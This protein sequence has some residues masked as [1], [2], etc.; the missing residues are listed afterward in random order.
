MTDAGEP[1]CYEEAMSD[2]NKEEWSEA[3][4]DE[5][6][7]LYENDT[8]ELVNLPKGKKALKNKWVYRVKT[9]E[10]TSHP[11][12]KVRLVVKGFS[13]KKVIDYGEIFSPVVKMSLVRVVLGMAA[14]M[15]LE[16]EQLD[17]KTAFL[18]GDLEEEIYMEQ[19]EGFMVA[20]KEHL[21]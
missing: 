12:Y 20:G 21:V 19:P 16:I 9:E 6:N 8:F 3:M 10:N 13:Q 5:M 4:Q 11:R 2:E 15:D 17:V 14:T 18:H 1:S 7:S